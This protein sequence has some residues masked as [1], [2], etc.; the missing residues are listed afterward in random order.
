MLERSTITDQR[1]SKG[2]RE[3]ERKEK[4]SWR[5]LPSVGKW[6]VTNEEELLIESEKGKV[7][8]VKEQI[9]IALAREECIARYNRKIAYTS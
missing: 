8:P 9:V 1:S 4:E 6:M 7:N 2:E 3:Q 5:N